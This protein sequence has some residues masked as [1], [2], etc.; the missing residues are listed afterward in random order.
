MS[1]AK[2]K[3]AAG[4]CD[5]LA[6]RIVRSRGMCQYPLCGRTEVVWAHIFG[7]RHM[8]VRC[9]EDNAWALCS[10]HHTLVDDYPHEKLGLASVT[11]GMDRYWEL[12]AQAEAYRDLPNK[13]APYW[14]ALAPVLQERC[15][16]LGLSDKRR[17]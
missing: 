9:E 15:R 11:I 8:G 5:D 16:E 13:G 4:L 10:T 7:R 2:R 1:V 6:A 14:E 3:G 17:P 12:Y